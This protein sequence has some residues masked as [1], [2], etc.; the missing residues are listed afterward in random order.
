MAISKVSF[1][2]DDGNL[3]TPLAGQDH[4]SA[5]IFDT[6]T[7]PGTTVDG[8]IF[9]IFSVKD[10]ESIGVTAF[11]GSD[12]ASNYE[13]GIPHLH[14][15]E[16]FRLNPGATLYISFADCSANW[17]IID[18][19]QRMAQG[20]VRQIGVWTRQKLLEAGAT[21]AD[22][23]SLRVVADMNAK[24]ETLAGIN[25]PVSILLHAD[26]TAIDAAGETTNLSLLPS[27]IS[28]YDRVTVLLGQ[29]NSANV[30]AIQLAETN[31]VSVGC[32]GASLGLVSRASVGTSIAWV[33]QFN[34]AGGEMDS[35]ALGFGDVG[36]D[37]GALK[38]VYPLEAITPAQL[39]GL[40]DKGYVFPMMYTGLSGTFMS[41]DRTASN[42]DY[43]RIN[44]NRT[45]DKSRRNMR[46]VLLPFLNSPVKVDSATGE[47]SAAQIKIYKVAC[48]NV[49]QAM[50]D[51][52]DISGF[53]VNIEAAQNILLTDT[54]KITY[55]IVP[56]GIASQIE[57]TEAFGV[58]TT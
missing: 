39:S 43:N 26:A 5:L 6:T 51:D 19:L 34:C 23:Y 15:S 29:G 16:F 13:F 46:T 14:I 41:S 11:D 58:S 30:K 55:I 49:L 38:N 17:D 1:T 2:R 25:Q 31:N 10:A 9:E 7:F 47:L 21:P 35:V 45:I 33:A 36:I 57:V 37:S 27:V 28:T 42:S 20:K 24:A 22:P 8:D 3:A 32:V 53:Q 18:Q 52:G 50:Q 48:E 56:N 54:L 44:R 4:I 12:G 40:E